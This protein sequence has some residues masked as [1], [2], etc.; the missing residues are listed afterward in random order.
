MKKK[1]ICPDTLLHKVQLKNI[2]NA[3]T[4]EVIRTNSAADQ[5]GE[6]MSRRYRGV[7]DEDEEDKD[8]DW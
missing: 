8:N 7:W 3:S 1:Y 2:I 6:V 5:N 4:P